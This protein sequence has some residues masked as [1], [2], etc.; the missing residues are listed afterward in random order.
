[1]GPLKFVYAIQSNE[2]ANNPS[3]NTLNDL[4]VSYN[5]DTNKYVLEVDLD[6]VPNDKIINHLGELLDKFQDFVQ[7]IKLRHIT[8]IDFVDVLYKMPTNACRTFWVGES[9]LEVYLMFY[10]FVKGYTQCVSA[11][12]TINK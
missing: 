7:P 12:R 8:P 2:H 9:L 4:V 1:M 5:R 10:V 3:F 6:Y 11:Y